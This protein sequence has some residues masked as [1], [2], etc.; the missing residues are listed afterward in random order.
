M[1]ETQDARLKRLSMRCWRR[2]IK[3]M[4]LILGRYADARLAGMTGPDLDALE[5]LLEENDWDLYYWVTGARAV[6]EGFAPLIG[7]IA[8]FHRLR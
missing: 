4:D 2:G 1:A 3:E 6:P 7:Q 8:A 5:L